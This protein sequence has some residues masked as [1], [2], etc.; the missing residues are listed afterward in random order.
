MS[1]EPWVLWPLTAVHGVVC[2]SPLK[3]YCYRLIVYKYLYTFEPFV[4]NHPSEQ[5]KWL[6]MRWWLPMKGISIVYNFCSGQ[7]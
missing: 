3:D 1:C 5:G 4:C 6:G 7:G 2:Y